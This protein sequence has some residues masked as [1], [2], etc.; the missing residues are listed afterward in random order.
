LSV[1]VVIKGVSPQTTNVVPCLS[2]K[3]SLAVLTACAVPSCSSWKL[4]RETSPNV[5][6][7]LSDPWPTIVTRY[8]TPDCLTLSTTCSIIDLPATSCSTLYLLDFIRVPFPAASTI[9][10]LCMCVTL[11]QIIHFY[12]IIIKR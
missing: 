7:T 11:H 10:C 2:L 4:Y 9:A 1:P 8:S 12:I 5:S 3:C 6:F